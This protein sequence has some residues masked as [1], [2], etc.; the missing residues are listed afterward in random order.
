MTRDEYF[1]DLKNNI[2]SLSLDEQ[3]EALQ[4]YSDYFDDA[5]DDEKAMEELGSPEEVAAIIREKFSNALVKQGKEN[6]SED[7]SQSGNFTS[8]EDGLHFCFEPSE[9]KN[10]DF[11]FGAAEVVFINGSK[12]EIET[13]GISLDGLNCVIDQN[14]TLIV[15]NTRK[16]AH[17]RFWTHERSSRVIPRILVT[18]PESASVDFFRLCLGAGKLTTKNSLLNYKSGIIEVGAGNLVIQNVNGEK[19]NIRCGM[20]NLELSG[21]LTGRTNVDCGMGAV[22]LKLD[23]NGNLCSYDAQVGMGSFRFND[24]KKG[25]V[26]NCSCDRKD[27]HFSVN[28]GMGDVSI[29]T[30]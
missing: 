15:K 6:Q 2:Q 17:L 25:G 8:S 29:F 10:L 28:V 19:T 22:K 30:K 23:Q 4:Y 12:F 20:G 5:G 11:G 3:S 14:G 24:F 9:V 26:G 16:L 21:K 1:R 27:T 13:R 7:S 18:I